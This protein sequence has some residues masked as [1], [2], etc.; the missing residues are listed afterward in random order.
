MISFPSFET[1]VS[2]KFC[3]NFFMFTVPSSRME[4]KKAIENR[5]PVY[6][7]FKL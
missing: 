5:T 3:P 2:K 4:H 1:A 6:F 7:S